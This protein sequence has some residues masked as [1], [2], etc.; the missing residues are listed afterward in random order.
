M[1]ETTIISSYSLV[2]ESSSSLTE[3]MAEINN[4][5]QGVGLHFVLDDN[6]IYNCDPFLHASTL[7]W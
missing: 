3:A 6:A 1:S 7:S 2:I 4:C 5:L